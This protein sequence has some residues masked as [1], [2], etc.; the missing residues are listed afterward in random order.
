MTKVN[1]DRIDRGVVLGDKV[2]VAEVFAKHGFLVLA[3]GTEEALARMAGA[4]DGIRDTPD[5]VHDSGQRGLLLH[6]IA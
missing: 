4:E 6:P 1:A 3:N 5:Q 2:L